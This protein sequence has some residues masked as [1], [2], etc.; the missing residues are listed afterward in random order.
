MSSNNYWQ[1]LEGLVKLLQ[2]E[3]SSCVGVVATVIN[4]SKRLGHL[5]IDLKRSIKLILLVEK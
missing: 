5:V 4:P 3:V 2:L 1:D